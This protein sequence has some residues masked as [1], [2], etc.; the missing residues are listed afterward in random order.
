MPVVCRRW[1]GKHEQVVPLSRRN[2]ACRTG[3]DLV[4]RNVLDDYVGVVLPAP[5]PYVGSVEPIVKSRRGMNP[6]CDFQRLLATQ[7]SMWKE[8]RCRSCSASESDETSA[9][10]VGTDDVRHSTGSIP[11]QSRPGERFRAATVR[12]WFLLLYCGGAGAVAMVNTVCGNSLQKLPRNFRQAKLTV[13]VKSSGKPF[14][15]RT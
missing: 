4:H 7:R 15:S 2:L 5:L 12:K 3:V 1:P 8:T 6:L 9:G 13:N 10:L 14:G 11:R